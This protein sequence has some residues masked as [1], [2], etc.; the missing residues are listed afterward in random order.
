MRAR[1]SPKTGD[2]TCAVSYSCN[3]SGTDARVACREAFRR[4]LTEMLE[5]RMFY[6]PSFKIYG[7]Q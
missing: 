3:Y 1:R 5:H 7:A 4:K 2:V 6:V